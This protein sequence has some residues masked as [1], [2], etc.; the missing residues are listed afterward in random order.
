M[1][2]SLKLYPIDGNILLQL[3]PN[4]DNKSV[5][6]FAINPSHPC[7]FDALPSLHEKPELRILQGT[8]YRIFVLDPL[9]RVPTDDSLWKIV[10]HIMKNATIA[11]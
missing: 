2:V 11:E 7:Y 6:V 4:R 5:Q 1:S 8:K 3:V 9:R 10:L